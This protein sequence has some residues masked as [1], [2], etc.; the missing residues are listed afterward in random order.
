[1]E[2]WDWVVFFVI[3]VPFS[4]LWVGT[5]FDAVLRPDIGP[6]TKAAWVVGIFIFPL[7]GSI[8][9]LI[10]RPSSVEIAERTMRYRA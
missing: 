7:I 1:M 9:Y 5:I 2:F 8:V 3:F 4:I 10:A 6:W